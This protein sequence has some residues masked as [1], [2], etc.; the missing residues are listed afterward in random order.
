MPGSGSALRRLCC[1][2]SS[3]LVLL[4]LASES[5]G[6]DKVSLQLKWLH[7][8]QFAGYY[9]ALEQGYYR[10]GNL[11]VDI[12]EGGPDVVVPEEVAKGKADFGVC[13]NDV[14]IED[15]TGASLT[16]PA[17]IFQHS[18]AIIL[19]P[20]R[21][22][23]PTLSELAG[24][25]LIDSPDNGA[26]AAMLKHE[27]V[28]YASLPRVQHAGL[29][30]LVAGKADAMVAY[31]TNE[32]FVLD[33]LHVP[34]QTFSPRG[35]GFDFYGDNLCTSAPWVATHPEQTRGFLS[36]SLKG[37][38][39]AL[40]HKEESVELILNRY[41]QHKSKEALMFEANQAEALIQPGL[42]PLGSQSTERWQHIA[43]TYQSLGMLSEAQLPEELI[44]SASGNGFS[45]RLRSLLPALGLF[46]LGAFCLALL[47]KMSGSRLKAALSRPKLSL[48]IASLF[49][50]LTIPVLIF[51]LVYN[52]QRN[53]AAMVEMLREDVDKGRKASIGNM[54]NMIQQVADVLRLLAHMA[55]ARPEFFRTEQSRDVLYR[56]VTSSPEIDA[57]Y[58]SFEDGYHRVVTRIDDDR[59][60]ADVKIPAAANWHSSFIDDFSAGA[61]RARHRI[62]FDTWQHEVGGYE[63]PTTLDIRALPGYAEAKESGSLVVTKPEINP[64]TGYPLLFVR[65]PII[66]DGEFLGC[67]TANITLT[68]L[69]QF[70]AT[71]RTSLHS[72]MI[73][74]DASDGM[75]IAA[76]NQDLTIRTSAEPREGM[77]GAERRPGIARLDNVDNED[78]REAYRLETETG[79]S[80]FAFISPQSGLELNA[81]FAPFFDSFRHAWESVILTPSDDFVGT[82]RTTNRQILFVI[83]T[84]TFAE[85][86]LIYF[87]AR[88]LSRPIESVSQ[89]LK[90]IE[91][92]SFDLHHDRSSRVREI[93][94]LQSAA[95]LLR[96][97]LMSFSAFAPVELLRRLIRSHIPLALG[98]EPNTL[99]IMFTDLEN[100]STQAEHLTPADLLQQMSI[101]FEEVSREIGQELGTV[102]KFIGDGIMA[103]WGAPAAISDHEMRACAGALRAARRM[104]AINENWQTEGRPTFR[105][106]I[107]LHTARVLIGNIGSSERFSYTVMGDGVN[108]AA[109]L[110][111][112]NKEYGT[113]VCI[114]DRVFDAVSSEMLVR[115]M[116]TIQVKGRQQKF[117]AY[118]LLGTKRGHN[119]E[120]SA[121]AG[122]AKLSELTFTASGYFERGDLTEAA[123]CYRAILREFPSDG[124]ASAM[125]AACL[126]QLVRFP[127][128]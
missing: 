37:W 34:Y 60:R 38:A 52:Y 82:L 109:R 33:Q 71:H 24:H 50:F 113:T 42:I 68:I 2:L 46:V 7:Q 78:V 8:F 92:L 47:Y 66:R 43:D 56:V 21:A 59:R 29:R 127:T 19:I 79:R 49:V 44:Y 31:S 3:A 25:P 67:A 86:L 72:T 123:R 80:D 27:G 15:H 75:I 64:D 69:S 51:I 106:R 94:Q 81:S 103:F 36:A 41:S 73:V 126:S 48:V 124:L 55:A 120:L 125:L 83:V 23:I 111:G 77:S 116:Q 61:G 18:P 112:I 20:S 88:R 100:F 9:Q 30:E 54:D 91:S 128:R 57:A 58:V 65:A 119:P 114:S 16:V 89:E 26:I 6:Q 97:S 101:Y 110:E 85:F 35:Y 70:L 17:V 122:D 32:P 4:L 62:F 45:A 102:D 93:A 10:D 53:S 28:D 118:E 121:R 107:G 84:L 13:S 90:A 5:R 1:A 87:L 104:Q 117:M 22:R 95:S 98:V 96:N 76:D 14:L 105:L 115:P 99:T 40:A 63:I 74:A 39:Y 108:V 12:R 11:D